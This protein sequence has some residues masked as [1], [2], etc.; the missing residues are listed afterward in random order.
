M[1][2][3]TMADK[4]PMFTLAACGLPGGE[5]PP[6]GRLCAALSDYG[7]RADSAMTGLTKA[8]QSYLVKDRRSGRFQWASVQDFATTDCAYLAA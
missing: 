1:K 2:A 8:H 7:A 5:A 4:T 3:L 6:A